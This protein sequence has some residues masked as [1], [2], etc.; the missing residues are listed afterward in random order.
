MAWHFPTYLILSIFLTLVSLAL[1]LLAWLR[2]SITG[3]RP[4][5]WL[6]AANTGWLITYFCGLMATSPNAMYFWQQAQYPFVVSIPILSLAFVLAFR[7]QMQWRRGGRLLLLA[8][9]PLLGS[10]LAFTNQG[11]HLVWQSLQV[12]TIEEYAHLEAQ[13]GVWSWFHLAFTAGLAVFAG[14]QL[15]RFSRRS[16]TYL[17]NQALLIMICFSLAL[18]GVLLDILAPPVLHGVKYTSL[19]ILLGG[20]GLVSLMDTRKSRN[21]LP[22]A[23]DAILENMHDG[24]IVLDTDNLV[25][26]LNQTVIEITGKRLEAAIGL[27]MEQVWPAWPALPAQTDD[28]AE[29]IQEVQTGEGQAQCTYDLRISPVLDKQ[30]HL[31]GRLA[32]LRNITRQKQAEEALRRRDQTLQA[33]SFAAE[34]FLKSET[35]D[36]NIQEVLAKLGEATQVCRVYVCENIT[37]QGLLY[38]VLQYVWVNQEALAGA[39]GNA[40]AKEA[41]AENGYQRWFELLRQGQPVFGL[42]REFPATEQASLAREQVLSLAIVPVFVAQKW[43]GYIGF[44]E[45]RTEREWSSA[46]IDALRA[47]AGTLGAAIER[48]QLYTQTKNDADELAA[49][50]RASTQLLHTGRELNNLAQL[51]TQS[52]VREFASTVCSLRL[53]N[54]DTNCL[55]MLAQVGFPGGYYPPLPLDGTSV[56]AAAARIGEAVYV[57]DV[58]QDPRYLNIANSTRSQLAFP[59]LVEHRLIGVLNLESSELDGFDERA[60][61]I[62]AAYADNAALAIQNVLLYNAAEGRAH[63]LS[64]LNEITRTAIGSFTF[65]E[66][67]KKIADSLVDILDSEICFLNLW[68]DQQRLVVPGAASGEYDQLYQKL[69]MVPDETSMTSRVLDTGKPLVVPDM[70]LSEFVNPRLSEP[71]L[72]QS[73]LAVP[74]VSGKQKLGSIIFG[75]KERRE[76]KADE[77][78]M[79]LQFADQVGLV[80]LKAWALEMAHQRAREAD[81]LRQASAAISSSLELSQVLDNIL[82]RLEPVVHYDSACIFL[83]EGDYLRSVAGRGLPD[84]NHWFNQRYPLDELYLQTENLKGPVILRDAQQEAHFQGW[85]ETSYVRGWMGVPLI[86]RER[87]I[88]LLTMDSRQPGTFNLNHARLAAAFADQVAIAIENARLYQE[89]RMAAEGR[90]VLHRASQEVVT[91]SFDP[92]QIYTAIHRAA[93]Q[94]MR[95]DGFSITLKDESTGDMVAVYLID[96]DQRSPVMRLTADQELSRRVIENGQS[97]FIADVTTQPDWKEVVSGISPPTRSILAVPLRAGERVIGMLSA[98]AYAVNAYTEEDQRLL[99]MLAAHAAIAIENTRLI[100]QVQWLAITDP[101]TDLYNRRGLFDLGQREVERFRRFHR[102]FVAVMIDLDLFKRVNDAYGHNTGDLVLVALANELRKNVRDVDVIGRYGGEEIVILMP[103]TDLDGGI[104][105]AERLREIVAALVIPSEHGRLSITISL[106]VAEFHD[107]IPDLATLVDQA[108]SAMYQAKQGG[109]NRVKGYK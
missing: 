24:V 6:M 39:E 32:V 60:R 9:E 43:W 62:L 90:S 4:L 109:R 81:N 51:I 54:P 5:V 53:L 95:T 14:R 82:V 78:R 92:E 12:T 21:I 10:L 56:L 36:Q 47:A 74:M 35:W 42:V 34:Q 46:E 85:G 70:H 18:I 99:E 38:D 22:L 98:Q 103:E 20:M 23:R 108:D 86:I 100:K 72:L 73:A 77:I 67:L 79:G 64:Q 11:H 58:S 84:S 71:F 66:T 52:V 59:L 94:L 68:D 30:A 63:Q 69:E 55:D 13:Y 107:F 50:Y 3:S 87:V 7:G 75:F 28:H 25:V 83:R 49:L 93:S 106:G 102:P 44:D 16:P 37:E 17:Q 40:P 88:G 1:T 48:S 8:I 2:R 29:I 65:K 15:L 89:A 91:A 33:V 41:L 45:C 27:P 105:A 80:I 104:R 57:P 19:M 31:T 26:D 101:L 97:I 96:H 76:L 61:R